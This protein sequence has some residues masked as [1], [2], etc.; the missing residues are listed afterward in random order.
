[1]PLKSDDEGYKPA[2]EPEVGEGKQYEARKNYVDWRRLFYKRRDAGNVEK[3]MGRTPSGNRWC[4]HV[5]ESTV[6]CVV[7]L[8]EPERDH[9]PVQCNDDGPRG[10]AVQ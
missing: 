9:E 4:R 10:W 2:I 6:R 3:Q 5:E 7:T 8:R 1:M